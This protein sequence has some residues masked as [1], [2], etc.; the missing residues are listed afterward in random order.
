MLPELPFLRRNV[1]YGWWMVAG[2]CLIQAAL[3]LL[4]F[5]SFGLYVN[6][7]EEEFEW[8]KT[9]FSLAFAIDGGVIIETVFSW[10]GM[11]QTLVAA[12]QQEDLPLAVGAFVFVG[13]FVLLAHLAV[14]VLYA[15]LDPR[16]R[17]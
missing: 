2:G 3:G 13:V 4:M 7:L 11:G 6:K 5:H 17:L 16:I 12:A 14:D 1:F 15:V 10:P 8:S 9:T